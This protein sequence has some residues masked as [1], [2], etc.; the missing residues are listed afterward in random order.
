VSISHERRGRFNEKVRINAEFVVKVY[1][2]L[3]PENLMAVRV[4][5]DPAQLNFMDDTGYVLAT[6]QKKQGA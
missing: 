4:I 5:D 2:H 6:L 1:A 3:A